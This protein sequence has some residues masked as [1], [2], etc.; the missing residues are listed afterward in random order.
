MSD[1]T[2]ILK[3][4]RLKMHCVETIHVWR[5]Q[6]QFIECLRLFNTNPL[7]KDLRRVMGDFE[8]KYLKS[9]EDMSKFI[10]MMKEFQWFPIGTAPVGVSVQDYWL[11]RYHWEDMWIP[12][13]SD[14]ADRDDDIGSEIS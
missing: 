12:A 7:E 3:M 2:T 14:D 8:L 4:F 10:K 9:K 11:H 6:T 5:A 13:G 1:V